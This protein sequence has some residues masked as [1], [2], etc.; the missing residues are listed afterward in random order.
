MKAIPQRMRKNSLNMEL[1][2]REG[3]IA[4]YKVTNDEGV[5][6]SYEVHKVR[7]RAERILPNGKV[8]EA[9]E[10]IA[11]NEEFGK[12]AWCFSTL[13][14]AQKFISVMAPHGLEGGSLLHD[15]PQPPSNSKVKE[16]FD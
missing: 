2:F 11:G 12:Y 7:Q 9:R 5:V 16:L 8:I 4:L 10:T 3:N 13:E 15:V 14:T 1:I 6:Y